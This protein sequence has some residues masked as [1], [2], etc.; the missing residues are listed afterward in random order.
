LK[1]VSNEKEKSRVEVDDQQVKLDELTASDDPDKDAKIATIGESI[2]AL[3]AS[4]ASAVARISEIE[5]DRS[6]LVIEQ[7]PFEDKITRL[8]GQITTVEEDQKE[9]LAPPGSANCRIRGDHSGEERS[10]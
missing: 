3:Q 7:Q 9:A 5:S 8:A 10:D 6:Q 2:K 4:T 1:K